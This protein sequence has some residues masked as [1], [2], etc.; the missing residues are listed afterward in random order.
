MRNKIRN[1]PFLENLVH[2]IA[3]NAG[4]II[5]AKDIAKFMRSHGESITSTGIINYIK[6]LCD[7]YIIH[8]VNRY[9]IHGKK[10]FENTAEDN[11]KL[12]LWQSKN[13]KS[14]NQAIYVWTDLDVRKYNIAKQKKLNYLVFYN[15]KELENWLNKKGDS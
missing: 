10:L 5:S 7:A 4:K 11:V 14:Y 2:F 6:Y 3:D 12:L 13:T 1:V 8:K 9:D 15:I